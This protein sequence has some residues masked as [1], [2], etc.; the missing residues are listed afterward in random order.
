MPRSKEFQEDVVVSR[1]MEVFWEKGFASTSVQDLVDR[2]GINRF[3]IYST[4]EDKEGLFLATLD[5][6][7]TTVV[8]QMLYPLETG[9]AGLAEIRHY[10]DRLVDAYGGPEGA[11]G[12][13]M[14]NTAVE[15]GFDPQGA[16]CEKI[17]GYGERVRFALQRALALSQER[18]EISRARSAEELSGFLLTLAFGMGVLAKVQVDHAE[19][20]SRVDL[21]LSFL[22]GPTTTAN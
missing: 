20:R 14:I 16:A 21:A 22:G 4:F 11:R 6:Y 9:D 18:G 3:S 5:H 12:C 1:A 8:E 7:G 13:L 2:M 15:L 19:L 17:R 10:F